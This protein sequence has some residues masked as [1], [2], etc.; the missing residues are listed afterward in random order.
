MKA[1]SGKTGKGGAGART[2]NTKGKL[3]YTG[4]K[5]A[6]KKP[7]SKFTYTGPVKKRGR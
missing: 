7:A 3:T 1:Q 5:A 6:A 4:K 2:D